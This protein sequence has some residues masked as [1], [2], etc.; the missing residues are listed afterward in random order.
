MGFFI[1]I[2]ESRNT[3]TL[4][5]GFCRDELFNFPVP[6]KRNQMIRHGENIR[7]AAKILFEL[8]ND[9]IGPVA[10]EGHYVADVG[11]TPAVDGLVRIAGRT[12][13]IMVRS[14]G[15]GD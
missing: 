9:S 15:F 13:I 1:L 12:N 7:C 11:A 8:Y 6:V 3:N 10:F 2:F 14:K 4:A 5:L